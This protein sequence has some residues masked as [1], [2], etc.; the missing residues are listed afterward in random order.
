MIDYSKKKKKK[1]A[2]NSRK[3]R[4]PVFDLAGTL[5]KLVTITGRVAALLLLSAIAYGSWN[6]AMTA[7]YFQLSNISITGNGRISNEDVLAA[8]G[9]EERTNIFACN[10]TD[11]GRKIEEIPWVRDVSL[12]KILPDTLMINVTERAPFALI[13]LGEFY[14]L[15]E[16]GYIFAVADSDNGLDYPVLSGVDKGGLLDGDGET[17]AMI[18]EGIAVLKLLNKEENYLSRKRVAELKFDSDKGITLFTIGGGTPVHIGRKNFKDRILMAERVLEDL[19]RKRIR[20]A[21]L[22]AGFDGRVLVTASI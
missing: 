16:E 20:A 13:N 17:F 1:A 4:R 5:K 9:I 21:R 12:K 3:K 6:F 14:Y 11:M 10:M 2:R 18:E 8:A 19:D 15:D 22:E 7:P